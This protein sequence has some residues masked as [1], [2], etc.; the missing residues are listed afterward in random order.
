MAS[1][2]FSL[3]R[4]IQFGGG[5]AAGA[6]VVVQATYTVPA[7]KRARLKLSYLE[8]QANAGAAGAIAGIFVSVAS[9]PSGRVHRLN[10]S[11][12][13]NMLTDPQEM[14]I[15]LAPSE[16]VTLS[17]SNGSAVLITMAGFVFF[18]EYG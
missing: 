14:D 3:R 6:G 13:A 9:A 15:E 5:I 10:G 8:V 16:S 4:S 11:G 2:P 12:N 18:E 1:I 7:G 17:T